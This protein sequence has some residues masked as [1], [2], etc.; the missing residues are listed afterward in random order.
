MAK[1]K[2][3]ID[4]V[5]QVEGDVP[6]GAGDTGAVAPAPAQR[7]IVRNVARSSGHYLADGGSYE[8]L[9]G[10]FIILDKAPSALTVELQ[11]QNL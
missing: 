11:V 1:A 6:M 10:A 3:G 2:D 8:L 4:G 9:P 7:F 5:D